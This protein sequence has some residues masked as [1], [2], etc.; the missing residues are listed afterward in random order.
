[1]C[2]LRNCAICALRQAPA[3]QVKSNAAKYKPKLY[4]SREIVHVEA[5]EKYTQANTFVLPLKLSQFNILW[6]MCSRLL[7]RNS[8]ISSSCTNI[9]FPFG[10]T[11]P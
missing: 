8:S 9:Q 11:T 2:A 7:M 1:M 5:K 4:K 10:A 3:Y 6:W